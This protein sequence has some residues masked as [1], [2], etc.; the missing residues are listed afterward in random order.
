MK[1]NERKLTDEEVTN[2]MVHIIRSMCSAAVGRLAECIEI[3]AGLDVKERDWWVNG[4]D[5][6]IDYTL[7]PAIVS[8]MNRAHPSRI[9]TRCKNLLCG[10]AKLYEVADE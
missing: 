1:I 3:H 10:R 2:L 9:L 7:M 4:S 8:A 6:F 5:A